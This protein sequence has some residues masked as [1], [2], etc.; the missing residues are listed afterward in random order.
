MQFHCSCADRLNGQEIE[1][2]NL[3]TFQFYY[4]FFFKLL[5]DLVVIERICCF[6]HSILW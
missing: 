1:T 3:E 5:P 4:V 6:H 2:K